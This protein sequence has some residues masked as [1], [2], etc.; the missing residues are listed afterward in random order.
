M[1]GRL[2][3]FTLRLS[4]PPARSSS[5]NRVRD[6]SCRA[7]DW[8][9]VLHEKWVFRVGAG[10]FDNIEHLNNWTILNLMPPK[11]G[12]LVTQSVT[13][14]FSTIPVSNADGTTTNVTHAHF[15]RRFACADPERSI[16]GEDAAPDRGRRWRRRTSRM[17]TSGSGIST[18]SANCRTVSPGPSDT[19]AIRARTMATA[20]GITTMRGL[21]RIRTFSRG[22]PSSSITIRRCPN[23]AS[24]PS[25][26]FAIWTATA[27][28]STTLCKPRSTSVSPRA[29]R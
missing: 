29:C 24:R 12:S 14:A 21:R 7:S 22:G 8:P 10:W 19:S 17:A 16:P 26:R 1:D 2:R 13:D 3:P 15:S 20:L 6:F 23:S 4:T 18:S 28:P 9:T 27:T 11:S 5:G 25:A